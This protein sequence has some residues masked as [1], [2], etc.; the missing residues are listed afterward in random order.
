MLASSSIV[1]KNTTSIS[2]LLC[3]S[4]SRK[5]S[6]RQEKSQSVKMRFALIS[7]AIMAIFTATAIAAPA[8]REH[9]SLNF[10]YEWTL[11]NSFCRLL[12]ITRNVM[13]NCAAMGRNLEL[14]RRKEVIKGSIG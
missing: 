4:Q 14:V 1:K 8:V 11:T 3:F 12:L 6:I 10:Y 7:A 5:K 2:F 9:S 13:T